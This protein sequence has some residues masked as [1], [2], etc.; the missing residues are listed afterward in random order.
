MGIW[1]PEKLEFE[2]L[3][4]PVEDSQEQ[5]L[6][7]LDASVALPTAPDAENL[8]IKDAHAVRSAIAAGIPRLVNKPSFPPITRLVHTTLRFGWALL[9][10]KLFDRRLDKQN[11]TESLYRRL[12]IAAERL[13]PTYV[14]LAQLISAAEG[15]SRKH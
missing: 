12:R 14:K 13:G 1:G 7:Q 8:W 6:G 15:F 5:P 9:S 10:W 3:D 11:R 2:I 4:R